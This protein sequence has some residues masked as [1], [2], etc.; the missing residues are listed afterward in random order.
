MGWYNFHNQPS[1][2]L[3]IVRSRFGRES[4]PQMGSMPGESLQSAMQALLHQ[5][6]QPRSRTP[7]FDAE[8]VQREGQMRRNLLITAVS[9]VLLI[10][11]AALSS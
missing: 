4:P 7:A 1:R 9:F 10:L 3:V 11:V 2:S 8:A 6:S 5:E